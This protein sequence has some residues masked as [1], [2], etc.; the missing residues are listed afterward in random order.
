MGR[1]IFKYARYI[2]QQ[3][4]ELRKTIEYQLGANHLLSEGK[5][6]LICGAFLKNNGLYRYGKKLLLNEYK[7]QFFR[8]AGTMKEVFPIILS[9]CSNILRALLL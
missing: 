8:M 4:V 2:Y 3:A 5:A 9:R 6:L 7:E 1:N